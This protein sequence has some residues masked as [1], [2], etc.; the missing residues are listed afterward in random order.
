MSFRY[1]GLAA[2]IFVGMTLVNRVLE[3]AMIGA[4]E[5]TILNQLTIFRELNVAGLFGVPVLNLEFLTVGLPHL[6]KWDYSFFGGN[7]SII[8]YFLY[9]FTAAAAF[10]LFILMLGLLYNMFGRV[11]R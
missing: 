2:F 5:V 4:S 9:S 10:G 11:T 3:G 8:Q 6:F 1:I 7:A